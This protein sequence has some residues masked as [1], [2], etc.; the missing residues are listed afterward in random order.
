MKR[1]FRLDYGT[2]EISNIDGKFAMW[3]D[4]GDGT[5]EISEDIARE[6]QSALFDCLPEEKCDE[7]PFTP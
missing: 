7:T 2:L 5:C 6:I 3:F 1:V 4:G